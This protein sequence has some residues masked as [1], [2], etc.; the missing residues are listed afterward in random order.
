VTFVRLLE[1]FEACGYTP[2]LKD[3]LVKEFIASNS[4]ELEDKLGDEELAK[5]DAE[6]LAKLEAAIIEPA[7]VN[8]DRAWSREAC[9][10]GY[11]S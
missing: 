7:A 4:E 8:P 1:V 9:C 3:P 6:E 11:N 2:T 5:L 10:C